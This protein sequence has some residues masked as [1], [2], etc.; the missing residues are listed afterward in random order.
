MCLCICACAQVG[1]NV[2]VKRLVYSG[3]E[4]LMAD[5]SGAVHSNDRV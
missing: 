5:L 1:R 2:S 3:K 4:G